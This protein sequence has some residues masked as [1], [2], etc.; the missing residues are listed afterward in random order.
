MSNAPLTAPGMGGS[1]FLFAEDDAL[2]QTLKGLPP[3]AT[4]QG[5]VQVPVFFR[6]PSYEI[7]QLTYPALWI[8]LVDIQFE[9]P[10]AHESGYRAYDPNQYWVPPNILMTNPLPGQVTSFDYPVPISLSYQVTA[11]TRTPEMDRQLQSM[12]MQYVWP[13]FF[14]ALYCPM[15]GSTRRLDFVRMRAA[16]RVDQDQKRI[17]VKQYVVNVSSEYYLSQV[18]AAV[19]ALNVDFTFELFDGESVETGSPSFTEESTL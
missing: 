17:F 2:K 12:L 6:F 15:D 19:E 3:L 14:G 5:P 11:A 9:A 10:R 18:L 4:P 16:D 13:P 7:R 1:T 8:D